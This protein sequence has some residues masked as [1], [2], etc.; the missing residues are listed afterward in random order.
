MLQRAYRG[1]YEGGRCLKGK[2]AA[3]FLTVFAVID[4]KPE[5]SVGKGG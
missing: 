5:I 4:V 1:V 2:K 3:N